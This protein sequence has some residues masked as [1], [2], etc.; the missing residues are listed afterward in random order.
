MKKERI[1]EN[2]RNN[3]IMINKFHEFIS[4]VFPSIS[5]K[6]WHSRGFW[7]KKF[8]PFSI[9][10]SDRIISNTCVA[11]M[12]IIYNGRK[13]K[14][15]QIGAVGTLPEYRKNGLSREIM[16]YILEKYKDRVD[17]FFLHA[18]ETVL[19]FYPKFE[20]KEETENLFIQKSGIQKAQFSAR[21]LNINIS[22]D[23]EILQSFL[24]NR[25]ELTKIFGAENYGSITMWYI[26]NL[27]RNDLYYI[28]AEDVI[29]IK[30]EIENTLHIFDVIFQNPVQLESII[31]KII[32]SET[33]NT[34]KYYF[35]PDQLNFNY[36]NMLNDN[37]G[38]FIRGNL[39]LETRP[40]RFPETAV[41]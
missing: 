30:K 19:Q 41:T 28:A 29:V 17:F 13:L 25:L 23:Y 4:Q 35:P 6:E 12:D 32:E 40:F 3:K 11:P 24:K 31:P 7:T 16:E 10:D 36:D 22:H 15:A 1:I 5:F 8:I 39:E 9:L 21:K 38:L 18:N 2:Y 34:I 20:F 33:I 37:T 26:F 27:Y 14:A